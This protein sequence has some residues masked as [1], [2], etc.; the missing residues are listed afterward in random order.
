MD[1]EK[2]A[3]TLNDQVYADLESDVPDPSTSSV[4]E[5]QPEEELTEE[6]FE[7]TEVEDSEQSGEEADEETDDSTEAEKRESKRSAK[8]RISE[9]THKAN[10][11]RE[12]RIEAERRLS[13]VGGRDISLEL[14]QLPELKPGEEISPEDY[15]KHVVSTAQSMV[16]IEI[17]RERNA[18]RIQRELVESITEHKELDPKSDLFDT[19][20]SDSVTE[21]TRAYLSAN[22]NGDVKGYIG[23]LMN[24][25]KRSVE[26]AV[27]RQTE[28]VAK[29]VSQRAL[30]PTQSTTTTKKFGDL[31]LEEMEKKL[32]KV[33]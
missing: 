28:T 13:E 29:Q 24:P 16:Q 19:D 10:E 9:L 2:Q 1:D 8:S 20:L 26:K 14:P 15:Q 30:R 3:K 4:E 23:K 21:A 32:G 25:Y 18:N 22:P 5:A 27:G 33:Y 17:Q 31:S 11:E 7:E 6:E 12:R